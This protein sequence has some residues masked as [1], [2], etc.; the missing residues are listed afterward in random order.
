MTPSTLVRGQVE[1]L[2]PLLTTR[3]KV[4]PAILQAIITIILGAGLYGFTVGL[5]RGL[6]MAFFV[7]I[8]TPLLLFITLLTTGLL[9]GMLGL[10]LGTGI[11]FRQSSIFL[12]SL[13]PVTFFLALEAPSS[14]ST[15]AA[16]THAGYLLTH[17]AIIGI[18]G[19]LAVTRLFGLLCKLSPSLHSARI[20]LLS[21]IASNAFVGAQISFLLRPFFGSPTLPI[22]FLRE[23][24]FDGTFYES[25]GRSLAKVASP[26]GAIGILLIIFYFMVLIFQKILKQNTAK[27]LKK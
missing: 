7:A 13:A 4:R 23:H 12:A 18:G 21:W 3:E 20:T 2:T 22:E 9:N 17:T 10:V 19:L 15:V 1:D 16:H 11:G 24:P 27:H 14:D 25:V 26:A 8:K 5:W 6:E